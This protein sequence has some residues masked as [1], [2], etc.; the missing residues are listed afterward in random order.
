MLDPTIER[1]NQP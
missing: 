1:K